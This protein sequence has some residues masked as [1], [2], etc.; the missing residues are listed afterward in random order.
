M[1]GRD[2]SALGLIGPEGGRNLNSDFEVKSPAPVFKAG[3]EGMLKLSGSACF[4]EN[5]LNI[6]E[7]D[8]IL[9]PCRRALGTLLR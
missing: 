7:A 5:G 3:E 4:S 9:A 2:K 6:L 1:V 8:V